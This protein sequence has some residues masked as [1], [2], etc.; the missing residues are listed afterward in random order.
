VAKM[1]K[2]TKKQYEYIDNVKMAEPRKRPVRTNY[3]EF[4]A[5]ASA[6]AASVAFLIIYGKLSGMTFE[7]MMIACMFT[8]LM[9]LNVQFLGTAIRNQRSKDRWSKWD[10]S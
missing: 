5:V 9:Q 6:Y 8:F 4:M 3:L 1:T 2:E 10:G 7:H